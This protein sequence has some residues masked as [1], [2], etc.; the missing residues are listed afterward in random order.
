MYSDPLRKSGRA[1]VAPNNSG[2]TTFLRAH[3]D[4]GWH[5]QDDLLA[6][7][8]GMGA[9][10]ERYTDAQLRSADALTKKYK[11]QGLRL[12]V[13]AWH[14][15]NVVDGFVLIDPGVL[16]AR[17]GA[18]EF[19]ENQRQAGVYARL[20]REHGIPVFPSFEAATGALQ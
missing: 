16:K 13:S 9:Q 15:P 6:R 3:P 8:L 4:L 7:D 1:I 11:D 14:S 19:A 2:K 10:A 17:L 12:L 5:D 18:S 20:A